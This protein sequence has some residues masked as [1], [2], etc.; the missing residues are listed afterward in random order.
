M[1]A[2]RRDVLWV[3]PL[4]FS[5]WTRVEQKEPGSGVFVDDQGADLI[6]ELC[7]M[8]SPLPPAAIGEAEQET[9]A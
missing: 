3:K 8:I 7:H 1:T 6:P 2:P 4:P 9:G 5:A